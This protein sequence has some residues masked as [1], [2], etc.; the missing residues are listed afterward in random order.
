MAPERNLAASKVK[1][2]KVDNRDKAN[3]NQQAKAKHLE[4]REMARTQA[5]QRI[6]M[7]DRAQATVRIVDNLALGMQA[8]AATE[9]TVTPMMRDK[10]QATH[11]Q[12]A[13]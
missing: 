8:M 4:A 3:R 11:R 13:R 10:A 6:K 9:R 7:V 2:R 12:L 5:M 1:L